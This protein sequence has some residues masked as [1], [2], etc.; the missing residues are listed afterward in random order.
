MSKDIKSQDI[1][2][3]GHGMVQC[4][5]HPKIKYTLN[6]IYHNGEKSS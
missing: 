5:C 6:E 2:N 3:V 4:L 1:N